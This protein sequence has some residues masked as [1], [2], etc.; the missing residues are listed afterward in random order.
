[1]KTK[2]L[3]PVLA[4]LAIA[5]VLSWQLQVRSVTAGQTALH[6]LERHFSSIVPQAVAQSHGLLVDTHTAA[7]VT[8]ASCH[9]EAAFTEPVATHTCAQCHGSYDEM[10]A[11][12]PWEPN[13]HQSH[14]GELECSTCHNAHKA[15][16]SF[17][18][19]C[20]SFGMQVP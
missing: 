9:G 19:Q 4:V 7:N 17:C 6:T 8:C 11:K 14:M 13:P 10:A 16:V 12:T 18:D 1:M 2:I 15:S 5:I 3:L 20:H